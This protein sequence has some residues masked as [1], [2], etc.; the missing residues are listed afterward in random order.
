M[1]MSDGEA[2]LIGT[3]KF[4]NV[5]TTN[6]H[7]LSDAI[8][9]TKDAERGAWKLVR[10]YHKVHDHAKLQRAHNAGN[11]KLPANS[12]TVFVHPKN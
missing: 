2:R 8:L 6:R 4:T 9:G 1:K 3:V 11:K 7:Y 10:A 12:R 5:D